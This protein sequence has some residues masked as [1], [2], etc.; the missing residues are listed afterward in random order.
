MTIEII[1]IGS[2]LLSGFTVNTNT[3]FISKM[4]YSLGIPTTYHTIAS[5]DPEKLKYDLL[6][7]LKRNRFVIT[8]GGLGPTCDDNTKRV[9]AEIFGSDF[10]Y[11]DELAE[12]LKER[13]GE[14]LLSLQEQATV[15]SNARL[16]ENSLGTA[17]GFLFETAESSLF[18]LP[19][20]PPEMEKMFI[21]SV[22]PYIL[23][24][25]SQE[26]RV[27]CEWLHLLGV[28]ES[29][30]DPH[31]R[32]L[33][34]RYPDIDFGIYPYRGFITVRISTT[35]AGELSPEDRIMESVLLLKSLFEEHLFETPSGKVEEAIHEIF[36]EKGLTL[37]L[38][39]SCTGGT[40]ASRLLLIPG[41]SRYF[42]GSLVTYS[43]SM[44][45]KFLDVS[46]KIL[47]KEGAVSKAVVEQM[48]IGLLEKTGS[49]YG[50]AVSGVAGPDGGSEEKPVGTVWI[51]IAKRG[52]KPESWLIKG[53]GSREM[54]IDYTANV[55]LGKLY[56]IVKNTK[57]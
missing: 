24:H 30:V 52:E 10:I 18:M 36:I 1:A 27:Y 3:A 29:K 21:D 41:A 31:L 28:I 42:L 13:Y 35:Y 9:V 26:T 37:S 16:I 47:E 7:A 53:R 45:E 6:K 11:N 19:G 55:A 2:E 56:F 20:V 51:A 23:E 33:K 14:K 44:K 15:P 54:I 32:T 43:D 48:V 22:L 8:S 17:P 12:S 38:A 49:D 57:K 46:N 39:E 5:D 34:E 50:I 4:L 40:I 25:F